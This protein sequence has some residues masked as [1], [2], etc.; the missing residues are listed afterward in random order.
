MNF[1]LNVAALLLWLNWRVARTDPVGKRKPTTLVGT[2]RRAD[3]SRPEWRLAALIGGLL[4]LRGLLY[5]KIGSLARWPAELNFG[6]LTLYFSI[7]DQTAASLGRMTLFSILSFGAG[8]AVLYLWLLLL[9]ILQGP[10]PMRSFV[11]SQLGRADG[12]RRRTKLLLPL[13]AGAAL[14]WAISRLFNAL[15]VLPW[16]VSEWRRLGE[17]F[18]V[19]AGGYLQWKYIAVLLLVLHFLNN[20]I[21]FGKRPLLDFANAAARTLLVPLKGVPLRVGR[22]DLAPLLEAALIWAA[23]GFGGRLL[24][25]F[26][27]RLA[28]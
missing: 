6:V 10:E 14:W 11:R 24:A 23:A 12:W 18:I 20:Y 26:Y 16:P 9:S 22:L 25:Y 19:G 28:A 15:G 27:V 2:L 1:I 7:P 13:F 4:L 3:G 21:Y 8:L 5:W 17:A